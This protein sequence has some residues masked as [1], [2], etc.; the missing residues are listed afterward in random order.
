MATVWTMNGLSTRVVT[1]ADG[2]RTTDGL[3]SGD[4][5]PVFL[6]HL[7]FTTWTQTAG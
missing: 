1:S 5:L 2:V 3:R 7:T 6:P 4:P